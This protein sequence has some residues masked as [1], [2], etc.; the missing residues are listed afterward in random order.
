[1]SVFLQNRRSILVRQPFFSQPK[2]HTHTGWPILHCPRND[3]ACLTLSSHKGTI[4]HWPRWGRTHVMWP[5]YRVSWELEY[6]ASQN[7]TPAQSQWQKFH[8][9]DSLLWERYS[10]HVPHVNRRA[11]HIVSHLSHLLFL[12][13]MNE[14]QWVTHEFGATYTGKGQ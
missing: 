6:G 9:K 14:K 1:M 8:R 10:L 3:A 11:K 12:N 5:F 13:T 4:L 7:A 2:G